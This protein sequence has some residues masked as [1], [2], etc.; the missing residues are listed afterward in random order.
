[1]GVGVV[2]SVV[3]VPVPALLVFFCWCGSGYSSRQQLWNGKGLAR[4]FYFVMEVFAVVVPYAYEPSRFSPFLKEDCASY[5]RMAIRGL[6][7]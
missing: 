4:Q 7:Y 3:D 1:V 2:V 5:T 6:R